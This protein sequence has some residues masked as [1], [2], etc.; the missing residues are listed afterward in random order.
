M[1]IQMKNA[2]IVKILLS[3]NEIDINKIYKYSTDYWLY[4]KAALQYAVEDQSTEI[5]KVLFDCPDID[6]NI[7]CKYT[8]TPLNTAYKYND[9]KKTALEIV[10]LLLS[11]PKID[12]NLP[13]KETFS[14][15]FEKGEKQLTK[16][17]IEELHCIL[18]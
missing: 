10:Q 18:Q 1:A 8:S 4:Q 2:E 17:L 3:K 13:S 7:I 5:G 6:I 12:V 11:N 14:A 16:E 9:T 15:Y